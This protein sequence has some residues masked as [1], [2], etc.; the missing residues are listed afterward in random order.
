MGLQ[1]TRWFGTH[2]S[3]AE[4]IRR[5]RRGAQ[6]G[7]FARDLPATVLFSN[8]DVLARQVTALHYQDDLG[9]KVNLAAAA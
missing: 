7:C 6:P 9:L 8:F 3:E 4:R 5:S 1:P 2:P